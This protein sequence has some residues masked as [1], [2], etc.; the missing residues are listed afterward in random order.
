MDR[1]PVRIAAISLVVT[2]CLLALKFAAAVA[3]DSIAVFGDAVDSGA[4][5]VAGFAALISVRIAAEP[6]DDRWIRDRLDGAR[7]WDR[8]ILYPHGEC[9]PEPSTDQD[10]ESGCRI[11]APA[12]LG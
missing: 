5:L 2:A 1:A 8:N 12:G 3:S 10:M 4:D 7:Q 11:C 6:A 9:E